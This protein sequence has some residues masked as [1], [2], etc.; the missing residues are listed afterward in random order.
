[1]AQYETMEA[2]AAINQALLKPW[3]A[4]NEIEA[5]MMEWHCF[6]LANADMQHGF[7]WTHLSTALQHQTSQEKG[8]TQTDC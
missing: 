3:P 4:G 5:T 6:F 8:H 2:T 7:L 1:M